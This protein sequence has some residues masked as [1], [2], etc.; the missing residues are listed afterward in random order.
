MQT[1]AVEVAYDDGQPE[2]FLT[3]S[4]NDTISVYFDGIGGTIL[5]SIKIAFRRQGTI[6]MGINKR[7]PSG[8]GLLLS[9]NL[10]KF[11]ENI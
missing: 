9:E 7:E 4:Q 5:E 2:G 10:Q 11:A 6:K 3:L 8:T 1:S